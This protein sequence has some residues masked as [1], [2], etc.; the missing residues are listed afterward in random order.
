[1]TERLTIHPKNPQPR[2]LQQLAKIIDTGEL[3]VL[4]TECTYV[5]AAKIGAKS[6]LEQL[7]RIRQLP[8]KHHFSLLCKDLSEIGTYAKVDNATYRLL[9]NLLPGPYT[10]ILPATHDVPRRLQHPSKKTIGLRV[11]SHL[12]CQDLLALLTE[13]LLCS[14]LQLAGSELPLTDPE[15][16][17]PSLNGQV[18]CMVDA[19]VGQLV[20]TTVV[21]AVTWPPTILRQGLGNHLSEVLST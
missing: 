4:P 11:S 12:I 5:F 10:F 8:D 7:I 21:D 3:V 9:K 15:D 6:A 13:P 16:M 14:T 19:G 17:L 2:L 18:A 1:M 20:G